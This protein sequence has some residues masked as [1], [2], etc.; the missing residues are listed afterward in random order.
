MLTTNLHMKM[1]EVF[2]SEHQAI[3]LVSLPLWFSME[4][5]CCVAPVNHGESLLLQRSLCGFMLPQS[6]SSMIIIFILANLSR[7]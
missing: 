6:L 5:K 2:A 7:V 4:C 3:F 1:L